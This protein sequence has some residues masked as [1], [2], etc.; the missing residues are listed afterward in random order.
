MLERVAAVLRELLLVTPPNAGGG[1]SRNCA[2]AGAPVAHLAGSLPSAARRLGA[3]HRSAG[4]MLDWWF[5]SDA[6]KGVYGFDSVVGNYASPYT[7]GSA[8]VLLHHCFGEVNGRKGVWGHAIGGMGAITQA[9]ARE[10]RRSASSVLR[11]AEVRVSW[12]SAAAPR[13]R[14]R[15][16][17]RL[18]ARAVV[19]NVNPRCCTCRWSTRR[20]RWRV[21]R[22]HRALALRLGDLPHERGAVRAAALHRPARPRPHTGAG[23]VIAPSLG[24]LERA[25]LDARRDGW[26][27]EPVVEMLIPS[28]LDDSLAPP[29]AHVASLFCQHFAPT[30]PDGASWDDCAKPRPSS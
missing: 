7:P 20:P 12:S 24:Y 19:A 18:G 17:R 22:A 4:E 14:A 21:P 6:L 5:E 15:R 16:R 30:L 10:A 29:G 3:V 25:Y 13:R 1:G 28:T 23:M 2:A 9:M 8:Y 11:E 26:S 27:R